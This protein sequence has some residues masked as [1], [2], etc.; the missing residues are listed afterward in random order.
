MEPSL[1]EFVPGSR[2][3]PGTKEYEYFKQR[4]E[5]AD[6]KFHGLIGCL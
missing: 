3:I 4:K 2:F 5:L 1:F 6:E